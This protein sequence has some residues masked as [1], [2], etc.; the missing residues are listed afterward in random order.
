[1]LRRLLLQR[2]ENSQAG[3]TAAEAT[4]FA[5][6]VEQRVRR[7]LQAEEKPGESQRGLVNQININITLVA[8]QIVQ[9]AGCHVH[10][11]TYRR[12]TLLM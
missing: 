11:A 10:G 3:F 1:M 6:I 4:S 12:S 5:K 7:A 8:S 2:K 9:L